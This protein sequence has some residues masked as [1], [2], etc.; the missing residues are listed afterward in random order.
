ME[1]N[2][3][4]AMECLTDLKFLHVRIQAVLARTGFSP[5]QNW[6]NSGTLCLTLWALGQDPHPLV[7]PALFVLGHEESQGCPLLVVHPY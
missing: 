6:G 2:R 5:R 7:L 4:F 1:R 3:K